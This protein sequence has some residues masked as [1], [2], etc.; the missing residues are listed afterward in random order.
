MKKVLNQEKSTTQ[1]KGKI[2]VQAR[3]NNMEY[4][5]IDI[6]I[7]GGGGMEFNATFNNSSVMS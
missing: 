2:H 4:Y 3:A 7:G 5:H 1:N 6:P